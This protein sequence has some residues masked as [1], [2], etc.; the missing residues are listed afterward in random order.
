MF[1]SADT[2][3]TGMLGIVVLMR[4]QMSEWK[5]TYF[6]YD[7]GVIIRECEM[8]V[9]EARAFAE[10]IGYK[11]GMAVYEIFQRYEEFKCRANQKPKSDL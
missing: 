11:P 10:K 7:E 9:E 4:S 3:I 8:T 6:N 2:V 5:T 1:T